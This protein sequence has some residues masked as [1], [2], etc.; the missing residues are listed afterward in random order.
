MRKVLFGTAALM[1]LAVAACGKPFAPPTASPMPEATRSPTPVPTPIRTP[2]AT[3]VTVPAS[4]DTTGSTDASTALN[5]WLRTVP[6]GSTIVFPPD[7]VYRM[8]TGLVFTDRHGLVFEGNGATLKSNGTAGCSRDC[9]L[10]YLLERNTGISVRNFNLVGNSPTPGVL[11]R[12]W[13]HASA[14]TIIGGGDVEISQVT[15]RDVGGDGLT[16][17]GGG[18]DTPD[19]VHFHDSRVISSGRNGVA[20]IAGSNVTVE[21]VAFETVGYTVFDIEPNT[22]SQSARNIRFVDNTAGT[23]D[24]SFLSAEGAPGSIVSGVTVSGNT[25]T[26][27][28]LRTAIALA[29]RQNIVFTNNTSTVPARGPVL[30]FAYV[31]GLTVTGNVQPLTS[32]GLASIVGCT[33]VTYR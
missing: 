33:G 25:V 30:R 18:V 29:R 2:S 7:A 10:F 1:V 28:S 3:D 23:W 4:I 13:E 21:G 19:R 15:I 32:G 26:G 8:D 22:S 9:S 5:D 27:G 14:I 16:L 31:D 6:D 20:V 24:N 12:A 17:S 11:N